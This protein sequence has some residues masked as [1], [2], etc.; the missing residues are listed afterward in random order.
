MARTFA[1]VLAALAGTAAKELLDRNLAYASPFAD[2]PVRLLLISI[3]SCG[4]R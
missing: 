4:R 3:S 2:L 1:L